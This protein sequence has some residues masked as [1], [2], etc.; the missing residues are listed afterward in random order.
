MRVSTWIWYV[1]LSCIAG[2]FVL[3]VIMNVMRFES[4]EL[5]QVEL[6]DVPVPDDIGA[7]VLIKGGTFT[8]GNNKDRKSSPRY[9]PDEA[10]LEI[11]VK[12]FRIGKYPVT[13]KEMCAFLNSPTAREQDRE[14][15][16]NHKDL[17][18]GRMPQFQ[19]STVVLKDDK[20]Y[21]PR[22]GAAN[23]PA[24]Q[25]TWLGAVRYC[26]WL[27]RE[28]GKK[29]RLPTEAEW[30][31]AA[32][33]QE[34][35]H[36]PWGNEEPDLRHGPRYNRAIHRT[37]TW[38]TTPVG[39]HPANSTPE[40]VHDMLGF[41]IGEWCTNKYVERPTPQ[42]A[43]DKEVD[44]S[45]LTTHRVVRGYYHRLENRKRTNFISWFFLPEVGHRLGRPWTRVHCHPL[46]AVKHAARHGFRIVEE[47]EDVDDLR[48]ISDEEGGVP[49]TTN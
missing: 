36:W 26:E 15:L 18:G 45:D 48:E 8:M 47:I 44:L 20:L 4:P 31:L 14:K 30:E 24:N 34:G 33:G 11:T 13:A 17:G 22:D 29:L 43:N 27:S 6:P 41:I 7:T 9:H 39:T 25:V 42:Q 32:K 23:A 21:E 49:G 1:M 3:S 2:A 5:E 28:T 35:R 10:P 19:Y 37:Q 12:D 46:D 40:G 16:Y 38:P